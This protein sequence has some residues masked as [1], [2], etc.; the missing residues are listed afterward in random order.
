M[1]K[2]GKILALGLIGALSLFAAGCGGSDS[3][4]AATKDTKKEIKIGVTAGPHAEVMEEVAKEAKKQGINIK[5]VEFNDFV[6]PDKALSEG[7]LDLNSYQH[8]PYLDNMVKKQGMKLT[9]IGKTIL[10]PMAVYSHK[11]KNLK[12][13]PEGAQVTIPND[14]SNGGRALLLI[15]QAGLI[16]LKNGTDVN[17]S[18]AD[19]TEN[20][21]NLK[22][23]ELDAAQISRSL[24]DTDVACVN[25]NYAIP[26]G[27]NPQKD[28]V[29]VES[30]DSPYA[31][32]LAVR[33]GDE[34]N[35]TYKKI[36]A[37]YQ[38][39]PIKKFIEDKYKGSILPAF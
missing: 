31:C 1:N 37:I 36:L 16:K 6:Q 35:E 27:L 20:P 32:V 28:A 25:T 18:V 21:K 19:I 7:D 30:K 15:Q 26:A 24:D 39:A 10:M 13:V 12:D 5:V 23:V 17:A 11:Y 33:Q 34:N 14:P 22:F 29:L 8:Q 2:T 9:S 38:S 3:K 4:Q